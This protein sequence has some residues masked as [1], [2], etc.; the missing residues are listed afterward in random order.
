[1]RTNKVVAKLI[2]EQKL[3]DVVAEDGGRG[4]NKPAC[5][6]YKMHIL[7]AVD[8]QSKAGNKMLVLDLDIAEGPFTNFFQE[9]PL[10]TFLVYGL[11]TQVGRFKHTLQDIIS[12]NQNM[13]AP[14][15]LDGNNFDESKLVGLV[16]GGVLKWDGRYLALNY[17]TTIEKALAVEAKEQPS[18]AS[19]NSTSPND[20]HF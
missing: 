15:A 4:R 2:V 9:H 13:F 10:K 5:R 3:G 7:K 19:V 17:I 6:G 20:F 14:D 18:P 16:T 8:T 1:M 11:E 12:D